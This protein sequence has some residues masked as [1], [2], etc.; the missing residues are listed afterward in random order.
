M[1]ET[2]RARIFP[3]EDGSGRPSRHPAPGTGTA[4]LRRVGAHPDFW[5]PVALARSVRSKRVVAT[6]F[7]GERIALYRG[8]SGTVHALED[9]CAHRQVPLSM[10]VVEGDTLRCCYHAWAYRGDGRISQIPYLSRNDGR[11]PRG[12]RGYPVR[13]AYGLVFVFPGDPD[14]AA[15]TTLPELPAFGSPRYR[16]MTYSRTVRCHYS[17]MHENLLDMNHQFLHRGLVGKL[18]P[19]LLEHRTDARSVEARYL[20]THA[21]GKRNH[22]ASLLAAEG[23]RGSDSSDVLT[24][25]TVYPYQTLDLVPENAERPAF[26]LWAAYV[27]EDAE[28]R[29]CHT[30]GLLMIEKPR[31]PGALQL[32]WPFIRRFTERVFAED[33]MAVEAEQRAWDEQGEDRNHEVFSLILDVREVLRSNGVPIRA[34]AAACGTTQACD[35]RASAGAHPAG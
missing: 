34:R 16:T 20:F 24:I 27:P 29:S 21:G 2:D 30:Y 17:F 5:Y 31:V 28:Q 26:R 1:T 10:G 6:A 19:E 12:V 4:D 35:G 3:A 15:G 18:H 8:E 25:R 14:K 33:R 23:I 13:E 32:A 22:G 9:R 11:P 7:A